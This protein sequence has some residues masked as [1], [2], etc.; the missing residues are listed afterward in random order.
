MRQVYVADRE[1]DILVLLLKAREMEHAADYLIR[2]QHDRCLPEGGKLCS[3]LGQAPLL[4]QVSFDLLAGR[5]CKVRRVVQ[6]IRAEWIELNDG[7]G[8]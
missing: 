6:R 2:C 7:S 4:G 8:A 5:E 1:A 3:R